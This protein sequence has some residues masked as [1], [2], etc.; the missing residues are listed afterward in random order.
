MSSVMVRA[1]QF[2]TDVYF[3]NEVTVSDLLLALNVLYHDTSILR[4]CYWCPVQLRPLSIGE[5]EWVIYVLSLTMHP[6]THFPIRAVSST[7]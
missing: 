2:P 5:A 3:Q 4:Q 7:T 6:F 1:V